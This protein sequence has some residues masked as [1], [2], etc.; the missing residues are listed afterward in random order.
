MTSSIKQVVNAKRV[1]VVGS[2]LN[3]YPSGTDAADH[4]QSVDYKL[5]SIINEI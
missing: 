5:L 1:V 4:D 2:E 3:Q